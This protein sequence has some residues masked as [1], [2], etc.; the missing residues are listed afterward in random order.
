MNSRTLRRKSSCFTLVVAVLAL[1]AVT[2][3]GQSQCE[4]SAWNNFWNA[5]DNYTIKLNTWIDTV[6]D[7]QDICS[8]VY[9]PGGPDY[10]QC[11]D[12]C[13]ASS[14]NTFHTAQD[15]L[16]DKTGVMSICTYEMDFCTNARGRRDNCDAQYPDRG[17][18]IYLLEQYWAC[19][20]ASGVWSCE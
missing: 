4:I 13:S 9:Q 20:E 7:C 1:T 2:A 16:W 17:T 10:N 19:V 11:V 8:A 14:L 12:E 18:D 5:N 3:Q 15:N 6:V